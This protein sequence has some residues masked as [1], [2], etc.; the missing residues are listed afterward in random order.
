MWFV[1]KEYPP[2]TGGKY[3]PEKTDY[4]SLT[5]LYYNIQK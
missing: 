3:E 4:V 1:T 2:K 5:H